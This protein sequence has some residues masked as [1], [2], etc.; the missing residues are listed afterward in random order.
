MKLNDLLKALQDNYKLSPY[1][2]SISRDLV[3]EG[4]YRDFK[5]LFYL[6]LQSKKF[7]FLSKLKEAILIAEHLEEKEIID[8]NPA[9]YSYSEKLYKKV[10]WCFNAVNWQL[11]TNSS[12]SLD[13]LEM[14]VIFDEKELSVL[15]QVGDIRRL[16][17]LEN[18]N[19]SELESEIFRV[20]K[21]KTINKYM[22]V[23]QIGNNKNDKNITS[24]MKQLIRKSC[25]NE[26]I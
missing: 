23:K 7:D 12:A 19:L 3:L 14:S 4:K 22:C 20:V 16:A 5:Q 17:H 11:K 6:I 8:S 21:N 10:C 1:L 18:S 13:N 26:T 15:S 2:V 24:K 9:I 25:I